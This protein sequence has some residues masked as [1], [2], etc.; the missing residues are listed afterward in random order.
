MRLIVI[1]A[2]LAVTLTGCVQNS[3][4]SYGTYDIQRAVH[5]ETGTVTAARSVQIAT[6]DTGFGAALG[7]VAGGIAGSQI[8]P[9]SYSHNGH[10]H[11]YTSAGSA[12]GALGGAI[13]GGL[14]GAAIERDVSKITAA[15]YV[16]QMDDG[17]I[18][19]IVQG[20][21]PIAAGHRVI[22]Q[23]TSDGSGRIVPA[24]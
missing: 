7:A 3:P 15:E 13:V 16:V 24:A 9:S 23:T 8:G 4:N 2:A 14:I 17:S 1:A 6:R 18:V 19:T 5:T 12:L 20:K 11:R 21:Q 22:L 10:R